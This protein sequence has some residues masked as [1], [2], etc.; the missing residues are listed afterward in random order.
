MITKLGLTSQNGN[1][2]NLPWVLADQPRLAKGGGG[3][4]GYYYNHPNDWSAMSIII[5]S[6]TLTCR[7]ILE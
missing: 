7:Q 3:L 2:A 6:E 4:S 5:L 1:M